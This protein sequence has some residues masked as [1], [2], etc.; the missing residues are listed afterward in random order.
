MLN[1]IYLSGYYSVEKKPS[2]NKFVETV[3]RNKN[4]RAFSKAY[5]LLNSL[6]YIE[7]SNFSTNSLA[8]YYYYYL[9]IYKL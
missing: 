5:Y 4:L 1:K 7:L 6:L 9:Y 3:N 2:I 8:Y